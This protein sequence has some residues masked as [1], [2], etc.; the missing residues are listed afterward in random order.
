MVPGHGREPEEPKIAEIFP[1]LTRPA[2][3]GLE[4]R[5]KMALKNFVNEILITCGVAVLMA[6][7]LLP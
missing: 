7:A 1:N 2:P 6:L 3:R 4:R 5:E